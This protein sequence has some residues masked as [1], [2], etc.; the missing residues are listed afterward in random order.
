[1]A[2]VD[3]EAVAL[4]KKKAAPVSI[5]V[6]E[7]KDLKEA[8]EYALT[9]C[10]E[11][12]AC[13]LLLPG[14]ELPLS[15]KGAK[16]C[17]RAEIKTVAAPNLDKRSYAS[18]AKLGEEK[19][20]SMLREGM[21]DHLAGI[22]VTF[23]TVNMAIAE[24][25]TCVLECESEDLRLATMICETHVVALKKSQI[26][27]SSHDAQDYLQ[28]V[29]ESG[30]MYTAFI[31]GASRTADIERVLTLGVHGPLEMHVALMEG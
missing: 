9:V 20:F 1:M 21:R 6:V 13:E 30:V 22:D 8:M 3:K 16:R 18:F 25:A 23:T 2:T 5:R 14:C 15:D 29:M 10:E 11:K 19:G 17:E 27:S 31:S 24:T 26:A 28:K 12:E 7:V 4:F